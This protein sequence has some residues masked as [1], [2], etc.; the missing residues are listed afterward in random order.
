LLYDCSYMRIYLY[1]AFF[2]L[3]LYLNFLFLVCLFSI[4]L[5]ILF[6]I[7]IALETLRYLFISSDSFMP[8]NIECNPNQ[9]F[10][11]TNFPSSMRGLTRDLFC[12]WLGRQKR[13]FSHFKCRLFG[14]ISINLIQSDL[15]RLNNE[16]LDVN[17]WLLNFLCIILFVIT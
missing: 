17:L 13:H 11:K 15:F 12:L 10:L 8:P 3:Q 4:L 6:S 9:G 7:V 2:W 5:D 16:L 1:N 14:P